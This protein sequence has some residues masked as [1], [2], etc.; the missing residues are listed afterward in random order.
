MRRCRT[1]R[2]TMTTAMATYAVRTRNRGSDPIIVSSNVPRSGVSRLT[3]K[4]FRRGSPTSPH[5]GA[6]VRRAI[7]EILECETTGARWI[8][9]Q[10]SERSAGRGLPTWLR[11][12][13]C[14]QAAF[15]SGYQG[16]K[17]SPMSQRES[18]S[19]PPR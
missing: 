4:D 14:Q 15:N 5:L 10:R 6:D 7:H 1:H 2:P 9:S 16:S 18:R 11:A 19:L 3:F 12:E 17:A 13:P 8:L